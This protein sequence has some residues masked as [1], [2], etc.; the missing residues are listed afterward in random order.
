L[1]YQGRSSLVA[2]LRDVHACAGIKIRK[3]QNPILV[4]PRREAL[5]FRYLIQ[6][7]RSDATT[8][9]RGRLRF[10]MLPSPDR[11]SHDRYPLVMQSHCRIDAKSRDPIEASDLPQSLAAGPT[12]VR[13]EPT[14][15]RVPDTGHR[16][17]PQNSGP[18]RSAQALSA[19]ATGHDSRLDEADMTGLDPQAEIPP[20][21][22]R[23]CFAQE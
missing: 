22:A 8:P 13:H 4:E 16:S 17:N 2:E 18:S 14:W 23:V 15:P 10:V 19:P 21:W 7:K 9:T 6:R 3:D 20:L 5:Q 12:G 11:T 1:S